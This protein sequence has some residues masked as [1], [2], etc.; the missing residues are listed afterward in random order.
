M[1]LTKDLTGKEK[2][3]NQK[4]MK[5]DTDVKNSDALLP[6]QIEDSSMSIPFISGGVERI[7]NTVSQLDEE[8]LELSQSMKTSNKSR[9]NSL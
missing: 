5:F 7:I 9:K 6:F 1:N 4:K 2:S 8:L 3:R